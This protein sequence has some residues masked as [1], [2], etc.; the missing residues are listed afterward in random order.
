MDMS[1]FVSAAAHDMKNS[2]SVIA[3][4]LEDALAQ[5]NDGQASAISPT[6]SCLTHQAL[7]EA[8]RV[9]AHLMRILSIYKIDQGTYP[10]EPEEVDLADFTAEALARIGPLAAS[11]GVA[12]DLDIA[13]GVGEG[14]FDQELISSVLVQ[15]LFDAVKHT[16]D[17]IRLAVALREGALEF[18]IEDNGEGFPAFMLEHGFAE[19]ASIN[20]STGSTGLGLYFSRQVAQL[21]RHGERSGSTRLE[22][23]G[24]LG[25]GCFV[26]TLP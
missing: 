24:A 3:A 25:G 17:R 1:T 11:R 6:A 16:R 15:S 20:A 7:Y 13:A 4:Y 10:F 2:V 19:H 26:L 23:G 18:R 21:H 12:V 14:Y 8:Q 9:N 5:M 22:N